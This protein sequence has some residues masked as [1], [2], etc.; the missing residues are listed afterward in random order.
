M[1]ILEYI[2][3]GTLLIMGSMVLGFVVSVRVMKTAFSKDIENNAAGVK[4]NTTDIKEN[5]DEL[6][7]N[8]KNLYGKADDLEK[9][10]LSKGD[11]RDWKQ[12]LKEDVRDITG[13][14]RLINEK[15]DK[16]LLNG[17]SH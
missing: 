13:T 17:R 3:L 10:K 14:L 1:G 12:E 6:K 5:S 15:V 16:V 9:H 2:D 11:F 7:G 4:R 8:I